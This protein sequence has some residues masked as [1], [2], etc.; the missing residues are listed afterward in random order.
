[1]TVYVD[2]ERPVHTGAH[3]RWPRSCHLFADTRAELELFAVRIGLKRAW[4]QDKPSFPHYDLSP[5]RRRAAVTAGAVELG[6]EAGVA[7]IHELRE[8]GWP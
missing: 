5:G 1:M 2:N 6:R 3:W 8:A 4:L 7:R